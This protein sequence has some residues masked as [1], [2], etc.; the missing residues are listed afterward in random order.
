MPPRGGVR[1]AALCN[2][3]LTNAGASCGS[4]SESRELISSCHDAYD[5]SD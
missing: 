1:L 5:R 3:S 2:T 4:T